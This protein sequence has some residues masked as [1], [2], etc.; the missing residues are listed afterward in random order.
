ML[1]NTLRTV[2]KKLLIKK[3]IIVK[4]DGLH[5]SNTKKYETKTNNR[6]NED[7]ITTIWTTTSGINH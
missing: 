3:N 7:T 2:E 1:Q 5:S 4:L 6:N